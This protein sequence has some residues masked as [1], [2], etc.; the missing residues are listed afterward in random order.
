MDTLAAIV[1]RRSVKHYDPEAVMPDADLRVLLEHLALT[2]SSFNMQNWHFVV[3]RDAEVKGALK[4]AAWNQ[5]QVSDCCTTFVLCGDLKGHEKTDRY[6][7]PAP[8]NVQEM[9]KG[10]I[11]QIYGDNDALLRDEA[12][13]SIGLAGQTLMLAAKALGYDS[14]P[15]IGFD[16]GKVAEALALPDH[17]LPLLMITVGKA[18][19]PARPRMGILDLDELVSVDRYGNHAITGPVGIAAE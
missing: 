7:R 1:A 9:M 2:P 18:A 5:A 3:A 16:P 10:F 19:S 14:C 13:R 12:C 17:V 6:L 8:E 4:A 11:T 15:M